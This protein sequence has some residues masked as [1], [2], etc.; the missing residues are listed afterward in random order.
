[1]LV[2][3]AICTSGIG[4]RSLAKGWGTS[5]VQLS[6][7][8]SRKE[9]ASQK[10]IKGFP[11]F[12]TFEKFKT[13]LMGDIKQWSSCHHH[14]RDLYRHRHRRNRSNDE[15]RVGCKRQKVGHDR[16]VERG[17]LSLARRR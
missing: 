17:E 5:E 4:H 3:S 7:N 9:D 14:H 1:M 16:D 10:K 6:R 11:M 12:F 15:N 2:S 13:A 8:L